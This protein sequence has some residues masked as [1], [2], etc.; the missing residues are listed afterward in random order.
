MKG[1]TI[2]PKCKNDYV[3][4]LPEEEGEHEVVCPK[5]GNKYKI[6]TKCEGS[7]SDKECSWEE[8]GEPRKTI[9]SSIKP[10]TNRPMIAAIILI[11]VFG[12]GIST[13]IF[14][15]TFIESTLDL[16][17]DMGMTGTIELKVENYDNE[18]ITDATVTLDGRTINSN[19]NGVFSDDGVDLGIKTLKISHGEYKTYRCEILISPFFNYE[20]DIKL[21]E[22]SGE[23]KLE[24]FNS[25]GCMLIII[26]FSVF[27][28]IGAIACLKRQHID[29]AYAG[30]FLGI[31]S[32][33]FFFIG[34]ILCIVAFILIRK[35]KDEFEN[36]KKG[37]IF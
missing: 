14:S 23:G 7:P 15:E 32:F 3:L 36:G 24:E 17:S 13:A 12:I 31:F 11:V 34:S 18:S 25:S 2:C 20:S 26:I 1:R 30:S 33:G 28:L 5:C 9:L 10:N 27:T 4:D 16:A 8:H 22:G 29:V 19:K 6:Q 35:S 37:R 21:E